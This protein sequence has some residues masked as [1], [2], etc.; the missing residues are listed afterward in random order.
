[1]PNAYDWFGGVVVD[2]AG[3]L[4]GGYW[5]TIELVGIAFA[6]SLAIGTAIAMFRM[7][8][9][10]IV[11]VLA[12]AQTEVFRNTPLLV[13]MTLFFLGIGSIGIRL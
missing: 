6:L 7:A 11:P 2:H 10:P 9:L 1:M 5:R 13:L 12:R 8:P 3:F 4:L